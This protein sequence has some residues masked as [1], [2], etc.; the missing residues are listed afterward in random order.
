MLDAHDTLGR[1]QPDHREPP[2]PSP[3]DATP[4]TDDRLAEVFRRREELA[5]IGANRANG[6]Q[7][8][9][10]DKRKAIGM[11]VKL[12]PEASSRDIARQIGCS[13][14]TVESQRQEMVAR[15]EIPHLERRAGTDGKSYPAHLDPPP[16]IPSGNVAM[17]HSAL[18]ALKT[19]VVPR[20][21]LKKA[22]CQPSTLP[23]YRGLAMCSRRGQHGRWRSRPGRP[24]DACCTVTQDE[25]GRASCRERVCHRV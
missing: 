18:T 25:I 17:W 20:F 16:A 14:K 7:L 4:L 2:P 23:R 1:R 9:A 19:G 15:A 10:A 6:L 24:G 11:A 22:D 12:K 8:S 3:S 5:A 21:W 13:D